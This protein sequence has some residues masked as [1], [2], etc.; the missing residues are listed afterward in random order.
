[1]VSMPALTLAAD[2]N[3]WHAPCKISVFHVDK[4]LALIYK[5]AYEQ[6]YDIINPAER[7]KGKS[8]DYTI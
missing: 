7:N 8:Q 2:A 5:V 6:Q 1:M 3:R 4:P